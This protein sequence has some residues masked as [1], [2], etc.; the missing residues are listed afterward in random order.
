M[1]ETRPGTV[2]GSSSPKKAG[3]D[4]K[5]ACAFHGT[6]VPRGGSTLAPRRWK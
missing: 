6:K 4:T 3:A 5:T 1:S 2:I